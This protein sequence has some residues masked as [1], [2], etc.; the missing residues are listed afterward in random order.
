M[1]VLIA[2]G[3]GAAFLFSAVATVV[4]EFFVSRGLSPDVYYEA[5]I[6]IIALMLVGKTLE[7]RATARTGAA[8]R[9]LIGLQPPTARIVRGD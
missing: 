9:Q 3:T 4:P 6:L 7:A 8:L 5:V 2:V 1:N